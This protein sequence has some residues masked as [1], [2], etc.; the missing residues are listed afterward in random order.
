[1]ATL[2][3]R[4]P[5]KR[6][7]RSGLENVDSQYSS[8]E[9]DQENI[10]QKNIVTGSRGVER[11]S[12]PG[13]CALYNARAVAG[14]AEMIAIDSKILYFNRFHNSRRTCWTVPLW[15]AAPAVRKQL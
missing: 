13:T 1:V 12:M 10:E 4:C 7:H 8:R 9:I 2:G 14:R 3:I 5:P 11:I 6:G 15:Q